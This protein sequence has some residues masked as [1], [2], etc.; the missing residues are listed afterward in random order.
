MPPTPRSKQRIRNLRP[1]EVSVVREGANLRKFLLRK[2]L[3]GVAMTD[4]EYVEQMRHM[5]PATGDRVAAALSSE[6]TARIEKALG[7]AD[8]PAELSE[9]ALATL[10]SVAR[11][12]APIKDEISTADLDAIADAL[13]IGDSADPED[14]ADGGAD[15]DT[16][17]SDLQDDTVPDVMAFDP[18]AEGDALP[19]D[20][21]ASDAPGPGKISMS[22]PDNV[23]D[24][25]H[26]GAYGAAK[27]AY[28]AA[29]QKKGYKLKSKA[30]AATA[31]TEG[32]GMSAIRK[33]ADAAAAT[34]DGLTPAQNEKLEAIFKAHQELAEE[35]KQLIQK[36]LE[37]SEQLKALQADM[38]KAREEK[39]LAQLREDAAA[40]THIGASTDELVGIFKSLDDASPELRSKVQ[41]IFKSMNEQARAA[42]GFGGDLFREI[43]SKLPSGG[44]G[45]AYAQLEAMAAGYIAKSTEP[46]TSA[47]AFERVTKTTEGR[48]LYAKAL[49]EGGVQ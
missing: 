1:F 36:N 31:K 24:E 9:P 21:A 29:L 18:P 41:C 27:G 20:A 13:G 6:R 49:A 22:K 38:S 15:E 3:D 39:A 34:D 40:L 11:L 25:H 19:D 14:A 32:N 33:S 4:E 26:A 7:G 37:M 16:E 43:G 44:A 17:P 42:E 46:L 47:Q 10:K 5:D 12:L 8:A 2:S 23:A 35:K 45:S 30:A 28:V 48:R